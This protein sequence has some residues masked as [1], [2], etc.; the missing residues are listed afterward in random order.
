MAAT[1]SSGRG[2]QFG[3]LAKLHP[4][5]AHPTA[6]VDRTLAQR[7]TPAFANLG[8]LRAQPGQIAGGNTLRILTGPA[9]FRRIGLLR[10]QQP[11]A[12]QQ[13]RQR[14]D[15]LHDAAG[16]DAAPPDDDFAIQNRISPA[17]GGVLLQGDVAGVRYRA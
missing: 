16:I 5:G 6:A 8:G 13:S 2:G 17:H 4:A 12:A 3:F 7:I 9:V 10:P 14:P 11:G 15:H 1:I